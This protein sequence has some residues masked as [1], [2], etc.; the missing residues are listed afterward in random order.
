MERE[1]SALDTV[2]NDLRAPRAL[3]L[4]LPES[5][6]AGDVMGDVIAALTRGMGAWKAAEEGE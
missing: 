4:L 6:P 1:E 2:L 3:F 5:P